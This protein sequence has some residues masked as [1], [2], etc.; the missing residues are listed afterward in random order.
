MIK[1][2][3]V[4]L[5]GT[6]ADERRVAAVGAIAEYFDAQVTGLFLNVLPVL[7]PAE[8]EGLSAVQTAELLEQARRTGDRLAVHARERLA[9]LPVPTTLRQIEVLEGSQG[10]VA[11]RAARSADVFVG[12][13]PNGT[14]DGR[15]QLLERVLFEGGRHLF[16]APEGG[17]GERGFDRILLAWNGSRE[18]ARAAAEALPYLLKAEAV[19]VMVVQK[20]EPAPKIEAT[21][22]V[23]HLQHHGIG[24][25]LHE[26]APRDGGV[27]ATLLAESNE[28][29]AD[30][31][32][33][34]GYGHS[35]LRE[36][37]L[38]GVTYQLMHAATVPLILAH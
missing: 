12:L 25:N 19:D 21:A 35:R 27:A 6:E 17:S 11:A 24:A 9:R 23:Q 2:V 33:M 10:E 18:A 22:F 4:S 5:D 36:W 30:L 15:G 26:L 38:G 28:R 16:L 34:G 29:G 13:R 31:V 20:P 7:V 14:A 32:V 8:W 3:M 1:D 37:L